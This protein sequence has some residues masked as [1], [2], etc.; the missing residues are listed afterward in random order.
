LTLEPFF[1]AQR[2]AIVGAS[3]EKGKV[4][5]TILKQLLGRHF[6][7]YPV[8]PNADK[9]LGL[10]AYPSLTD[11]PGDVDL[12]VIATPAKTVPGIL[13]ECGTNNITHAIIISAGFEEIGNTALAGELARAIKRNNIT[14]IGPNCLGIFD[15][16]TKLDTFFLPK[17]RLRRPE[18][19]SISLISQ[20]GATGSAIMDLAAKEHFGMAK[21]ISYGNAANVDESDLLAYLIKDSD[22]RVICMYLEG[23]RDGRKFMR[24]AK[25]SKKPIIVLKGGVTDAGSSAAKSHTGSLAGSADAY[26]GAFKQCG[27]I[28]ARTLEE[29][30]EYAKIFDKLFARLDGTRIQVITNGGGFGILSSDALVHHGFT[31]AKPG[32]PIERLRDTFPPTAIVGNPIDV[33]GDATNE[34][35]ELAL[36][37]ALSDSANDGIVLVLLTQTPRIDENLVDTLTP[38][39]NNATKPVVLVITGSEYSA[40]ITSAFESRGIPCFAFPDNA[41]RALAAYARHFGH[42]L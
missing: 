21:T 34:R 28:I 41:V 20:S 35:Y 23:M 19:G 36:D 27:V 42:N 4:G 16:H 31:L 40:R 33:L 2:I 39:I 24:I 29:L 3:R 38:K 26:F 18:A 14:C 17:E 7:L 13:D 30:F 15:A 9:I 11:V 25:R 5:N 22:T 6:T 10:D 1:S 32:K 37:A 8:N 12:A